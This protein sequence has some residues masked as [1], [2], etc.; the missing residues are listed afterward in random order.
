MLTG[1]MVPTVLF[2]RAS[3]LLGSARD[4]FESPEQT[5]VTDLKTSNVGVRSAAST[6][7]QERCGN[8]KRGPIYR[9]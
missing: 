8:L 1:T 9:L 6:R 7:R 3:E 4:I 2:M 5:C